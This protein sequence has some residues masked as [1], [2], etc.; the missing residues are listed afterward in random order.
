MKAPI[1]TLRGLVILSLT[2]IFSATVLTCVDVAIRLNREPGNMH[3][4]IAFVMLP[5]L[6]VPLLL[7]VCA[8]HVVLRNFFRYETSRDWAFAGILYALFFLF[9][10][11]PWLIII[12]VILN[13]FSVR[14]IRKESA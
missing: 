11:W 10:L 14:L 3:P 8:I 12:P 2:L 7:V 9:F 1:S 6:L 4:S 13:P 5:F